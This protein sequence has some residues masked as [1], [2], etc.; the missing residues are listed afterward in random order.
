MGPR[1]NTNW[2]TLS[3]S[4]D[5]NSPVP[6]SR[7]IAVL[8]HERVAESQG[9]LQVRTLLWSHPPRPLEAEDGN[10]RVAR[11]EAH[12]D[13]DDHGDAKQGRYDEQEASGQVPPHFAVPYTSDARGG[14][15]APPRALLQAT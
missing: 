12:G 14:A 11:K 1:R 3:P 2:V 4:N 10:Q 6:M 5:A 15:H 8:D 13:E 9:L 7:A